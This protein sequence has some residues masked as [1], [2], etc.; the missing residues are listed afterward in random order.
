[1]QAV[2]SKTI[3]AKWILNAHKDIFVLREHLYLLLVQM[4]RMVRN[5]ILRIFR[6]VLRVHL[7]IIAMRP[8]QHLCSMYALLGFIALLESNLNAILGFLLERIFCT[9]AVPA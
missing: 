7:D 8:Q 3:Y 5:R 2:N 1:M 9:I 4:E 6:I